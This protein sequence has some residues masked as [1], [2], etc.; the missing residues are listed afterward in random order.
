MTAI[1][2]ALSNAF[3]RLIHSGTA[4]GAPQQSLQPKAEDCPPLFSVE[5]MP[6]T[7]NKDADC[8]I[9]RYN[10]ALARVLAAKNETREEENHAGMSHLYHFESNVTENT[11]ARRT[12][13]IHDNSDYTDNREKLSLESNGNLKEDGTCDGLPWRCFG[14]VAGSH[15]DESYAWTRNPDG[16]L[17]ENAS[18]WLKGCAAETG[19]AGWKQVSTIYADGKVVTHPTEPE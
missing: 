1:G 5:P 15:V 8:S 17:H 14:L 9:S 4:G 2:T 12:V 10:A 3:H 18:H 19:F 6:L 7:G 11:V 13:E 16:S